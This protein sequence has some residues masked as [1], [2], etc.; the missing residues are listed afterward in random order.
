MHNFKLKILNVSMIN[1]FILSSVWTAYSTIEFKMVENTCALGRGGKVVLW[2]RYYLLLQFLIKG[3]RDS[4]LFL[5]YKLMM[6]KDSKQCLMYH[7]LP[8]FHHISGPN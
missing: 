4:K 2:K 3:R 5:I 6:Q 1:Y 8:S 7:T